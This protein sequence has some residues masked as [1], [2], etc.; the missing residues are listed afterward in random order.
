MWRSVI[1]FALGSLPAVGGELELPDLNSIVNG[2]TV[3]GGDPVARHTVS[4]SGGCSG[5]LIA[6]DIVV[7]AGHCFE[8]RGSGGAVEFGTE[9]GSAGDRRVVAVK[10][11]PGFRGGGNDIAILRF[12]GGLP[13]GFTPAPM[14][15][16]PPRAGQAV[17]VAGYGAT[18]NGGGG[19]PQLRKLRR[20]VESARGSEMRLHGGSGSACNGDSGGP[21]Y[22]ES[23][24]KLILAG[25]VSRSGSGRNCAGAEIHTRVDSHR[26]WIARASAELRGK[27]GGSRPPERDEEDFPDDGDHGRDP[28]E[29]EEE[30]LNY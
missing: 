5:T 10:V 27:G 30:D 6:E 15:S 13:R 23:G 19:A 12:T 9:P 1:I 8:G 18:R 24:G 14:N 7:S 4:L 16:S 29:E 26:D 25:V 28:D 3:R 2:E 17:I 20:S 21:G 11:H 22:L